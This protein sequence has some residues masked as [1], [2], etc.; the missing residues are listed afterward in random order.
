[1]RRKHQD[2]QAWQQAVA[3]VK[4]VYALTSSF[5][6]A[7]LYRLTSQMRRS[8]ISIPCNIAEGAARHSAKEFLHFLGMARGSLSELD[9]QL[10]IARE[11][12]YANESRHVDEKLDQLFALLGGLIKPL[13]A[14]SP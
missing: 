2:L 8:A 14:R 4:E 7:E 1:M 6:N 10:T 3:L 9:T 5:P 12:G 11:L 13:C